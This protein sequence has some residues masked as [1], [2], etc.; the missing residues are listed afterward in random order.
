MW[1][2][3]GARSGAGK[4]ARAR[5]IAPELP[6]TCLGSDAIRG[7][8]RGGRDTIGGGCRGGR[9]AIRGRCRGGRE[10]IPSKEAAP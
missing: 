8:C 5:A 10:D 7:R 1:I 3:F 4:R 2:V 9:D 6:A